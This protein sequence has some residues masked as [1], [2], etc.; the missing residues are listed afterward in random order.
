MAIISSIHPHDI[1]NEYNDGANS[2]RNFLQYAEGLSRGDAGAARRVL[3]GLNPLARKSLAPETERDGVV[4]QLAETLRSRGMIV[5]I[6]VGQ[7]RFRCDLAV[8][9]GAQSHYQLGILVDT[10]AHYANPNL[11]ERYL[12]QPAILRAF[13]WRF[14]LVLTKDWYHDSSAVVQRIERLLTAKEHDEAAELEPIEP[15][16]ATPTPSRQPAPNATPPPLEPSDRA[17]KIS[18]RANN[19]GYS[20]RGT[21][22]FEFKGGGSNKFWE[23]SL[24]DK[25]LTVRFGRIG[26]DG[27]IQTKIFENRTRATAEG[28]KLIQ[29]KLR[30][31]YIEATT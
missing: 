17:E 18:S 11:T 8:R 2:L 23:I 28:M 6:N 20:S 16:A 5:D 1:T 15:V 19:D 27:Q 3:E 31:G 21:R 25:A 29:E 24:D 9:T 30:K 10:A 12:M 7:S 26:T 14:V 22:R 13:G 4:E